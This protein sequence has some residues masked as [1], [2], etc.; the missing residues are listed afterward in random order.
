MGTSMTNPF[1]LLTV[2]LTAPF[3]DAL[4]R[5]ATLEGVPMTIVIRRLIRDE[6]IRLGLWEKKEDA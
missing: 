2:R 1:K 4:F 3:Y 6:S 5:I